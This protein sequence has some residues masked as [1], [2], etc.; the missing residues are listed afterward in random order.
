MVICG[1]T[2]TVNAQG[3]LDSHLKPIVEAYY[4]SYKTRKDFDQ[5]LSFYDEEIILEDIIN[6]DRIIGKKAFA[7]FFDWNNPSIKLLEPLS[8]VIEN[9]LIEGNHVITKGHFTPFR[10]CEQ[11]FG[12][13]HF[14]TLLT[15]NSEGKITKQVD[16]INY[17]SNLIDYSK[18]KDSN[19]WIVNNN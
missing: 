11:T 13:M 10:W 18:R 5:F 7:D 19:N 8:L 12:P 16:W 14:T 6:G 9:Q 2:K 15:F 3:N 17:P 4:E 1:L